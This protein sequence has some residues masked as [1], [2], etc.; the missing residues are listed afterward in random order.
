MR[1]PGAVLLP[2]LL[3]AL[4]AAAPAVLATDAPAD[5][6]RLA[7]DVILLPLAPG[8]WRHVTWANLPGHGLVPANGLV[9][10]D[11][12]EVALVD[13]PWDD[14]QTG[15]ILEWAERE[16]GAGSPQVIVGH[17]HMDCLGGL[18]EAHA[19]GARSYAGAATVALARKRGDEVPRQG[20]ADTLTVRVGARRLEVRFAGAGHTADN[21]VTW[22][23]DARILFGGCLV[24]SGA[25]RD[26]GNTAEAD[27][28]AWPATIAR[29]QA[30]YPDARTIVPGHGAPGGSELLRHTLELLAAKA[31]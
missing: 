30:H 6:V 29:L 7:D 4:A 22:L 17:A 24:R 13:T 12:G 18:A 16:Q 10:I 28:A 23:P 15:L 2:A 9:V 27:L 8:V 21:V 1:T 3:V 25:A 26:L 20:F 31:P 11:R 14:G 19:R 5:T